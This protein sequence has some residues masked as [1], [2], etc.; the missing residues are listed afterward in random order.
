MTV[1]VLT[2]NRS[3]FTEY[4]MNNAP[5]PTDNIITEM[6]IASNGSHMDAFVP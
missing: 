4:D 5:C 2:T 3:G 6:N 1:D